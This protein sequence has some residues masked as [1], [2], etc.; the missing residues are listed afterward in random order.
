MLR[1]AV[2]LLLGLGVSSLSVEA[3]AQALRF[4]TTAPGNVIAAGNTLGLSKESGLNGPG[5]SDSIGT[6]I[7]LDAQSVDTDAPLGAMAWP[8]GTTSDWTAN[9]SDAQ[10]TLPSES[11][12]LYA[13]LVW[14]GSHEYGEDVSAFL[15][16]PVVLSFGNDS[17]LVTPDAT[18]ATTVEQTGTFT[19]RY[20]MRS[21]E[22]TSFVEQHGSGLYAVA[23]VPATQASNF[24]TVNAAGWS[25][26]VAYRFDSEPIRN[27]SVF[28]GDTAFVD[29]NTTV[30]YAVSGFC[31][32]PAGE[33]NGT[34]AIATVE[35][36]SNRVGDQLA[37]GQTVAS[38]FVN[39]SGPNNPANNFF[40]SQINGPDGQLDTSGTFG[41]KNHTPGSNA[42]GSRQGWD[43]TNVQLSSAAGQLAPGQT[44]AVLRTQTLDDSYMPVLAGIAID[45][46]APTFLYQA[47]ST[48]V[49]VNQVAIGDSFTVTATLEN[50]GTA[51][52]SGVEL[53][54]D[55]PSGISLTDFAT[56][57]QP[58]D[59][60]GGSVAL[61]DLASGVAM[62]DLT[63]GTQRVATITLQVDSAQANTIFLQ[64]V[65]QY[66]YTQC[67]GMP[68]TESFSGEVAVL[69]Y[70][71]ET[72]TGG[73]GQGG[74]GPGSTTSSSGSGTTS[75]S[76]G[77]GDT[78]GAGGE[79]GEG[80]G[81]DT[82]VEAD[83][84]NC[85]AAGSDGPSS[86]GAWAALALAASVAARRRRRR[87]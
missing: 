80:G 57:G 59:V 76:T 50:E 7:T 19:I 64:P 53:L 67:A 77:S 1:Q 48:E 5:V 17:I 58:G 37:I 9:G 40:C 49:D 47:S 6:F 65:W 44:S 14:G 63:P 22:V 46:N 34:I 36:D 81:A 24:N 82:K 39:L 16:E 21:A 26:I 83:G 41:M 11:Q 43:L 71:P 51:T 31:A 73:G 42:S 38:S 72:G 84:C 25:I 62:G 45:V 54:L 52:A 13:E 79:G 27:L 32:P 8:G 85:L 56:D 28:V 12:V 86:T 78:S 74:A 15:N 68:A 66:S 55:V 18:T 87:G 61:G 33:I 20:Y 30:D 29:E 2:A 60:N 23:G 75:S 70:V 10:L 69:G 3:S 35:G 4:S